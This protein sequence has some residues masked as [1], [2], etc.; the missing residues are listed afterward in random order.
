MHHYKL[1]LALP[2][3]LFGPT[4]G[5]SANSGFFVKGEL[6]L[7]IPARQLLQSV[8]ENPNVR[9]TIYVYRENPAGDLAYTKA[10]I[11]EGRFE[12]PIPLSIPETDL[13][14]RALHQRG[15]ISTTD[16][17]LTR[18][19]LEK[20]RNQSGNP[21]L[22]GIVLT[23]T[24]LTE[25]YHHEMGKVDSLVHKLD[26]DQAIITLD[27]IQKEFLPAGEA[28]IYRVL[29]RRVEV[30]QAAFEHGIYVQEFDLPFLRE[31]SEGQPAAALSPTHKYKLL[32]QYIRALRRSPY[33][34]TWRMSSGQSIA[35]IVDEAFSQCIKAFLETDKDPKEATS[36][37]TEYLDH[38]ND[39]ER[40]L[41]LVEIGGKYFDFVGFP[42]YN[43]KNYQIM[44][45]VK[46]LVAMGDALAKGTNLNSYTVT[47]YLDEVKESSDAQKAWKTFMKYLERWK[48]FFPSGGTGLP[49]RRM[50]RYYEVGKLVIGS[51]GEDSNG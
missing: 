10:N 44:A 22:Q 30:L 17:R 11:A 23:I 6:T 37:A 49:S 33:K 36:I 20:L 51:N 41:K 39:T 45:V 9:F 48:Y 38:L 24:T 34:A 47:E 4:I 35:D 21:I 40:Y 16:V 42:E 15:L 28:F 3:L 19:E 1:L 18:A 12:F 2:F 43:M 13:F 14:L 50:H 8:T 29:Q 32:L 46:T 25:R 27:L 5:I 7:T 31:F 26:F